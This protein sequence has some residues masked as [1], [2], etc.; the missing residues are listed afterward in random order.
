[1]SGTATNFLNSQKRRIFQGARGSYFV[2]RADGKK[3]YGLRAAFRKVGANGA[4]SKLTKK[5]A[6]TVPSPLRRAVRKNAGVKRKSPAA[7]AAVV[8][9]RRVRAR[10]R[11][12]SP[13]NRKP[14]RRAVRKNAGI[15]RGPL[16]NGTVRKAPVRR[17]RA[18]AAVRQNPNMNQG[19]L[20]RQM[21]AQAKRMAL[22][23]V[24]AANRAALRALKGPAVRKPRPARPRM[25]RRSPNLTNAR[26][27][28]AALRAVMAVRKPRPVRKPRVASKSRIQ[29]MNALLKAISPKPLMNMMM[30]GA[31]KRRKRPRPASAPMLRRRRPTAL[32]KR[33][34][35][36]ASAPALR[37]RRPTT[38][39]KR[40][41][42]NM[43]VAS[44]FMNMMMGKRSMMLRKRRPRSAKY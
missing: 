18:V 36:P 12:N 37:R 26:A 44:P 34:P 31:K 30:G 16:K 7:A 23:R 39:R 14:M 2:K 22:A 5:N 17:K 19:L 1:M 33:R 42:A 27:N 8:R 21:N 9:K 29:A 10:S 11:S 6:M 43:R 32:R 38:L 20:Q 35:R 15:K 41:P 24:R 28:S 3:V 13:N 40:R 25:V 4:E